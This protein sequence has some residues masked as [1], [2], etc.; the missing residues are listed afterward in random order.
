MYTPLK[1]LSDWPGLSPL[2]AINEE[3]LCKGY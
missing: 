3:W 2:K 1:D